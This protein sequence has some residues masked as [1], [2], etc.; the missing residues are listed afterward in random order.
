MTRKLH[1]IIGVLGIGLLL[2]G[3]GIPTTEF[4]GAPDSTLTEYNVQT[5]QVTFPHN[6]T[7]NSTDNFLGYEI[8]YKFY[9]FDADPL[10]S[11]FG[12]DYAAISSAAPGSGIATVEGR[13]YH[14]MRESLQ[15][16]SAEETDQPPLIPV[17]ASE[18]ATDFDVRLQFPDKPSASSPDPASAQALDD[19]VP[20]GSEIRFAR[21][22]EA[23]PLETELSFE[24][25]DITIDP[26]DG[27]V[28]Q[29]IPSRDSPLHM[30]IVILAYGADFT[31]G[32]FGTLYS[33][34]L[35]IE[36]PLEILLQ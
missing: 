2:V 31:G 6:A 34:P 14:R 4:L 36:R 25:D 24:S 8:Y 13:G 32:T 1:L 10:A 5:F 15:T 29:G 27:D 3:C 20:I 21:A 16:A 18:R 7:D 26:N 9:Q 11:A 17:S 22:R 33:S 23:S 30:G 28:P 35:I 19:G 12:S